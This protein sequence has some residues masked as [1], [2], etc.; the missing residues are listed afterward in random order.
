MNIF[1]FLISDWILMIPISDIMFGSLKQR[2][3]YE[4]N[5]SKMEL[6]AVTL[7]FNDYFKK[8]ISIGRS[9]LS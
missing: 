7:L 4:L 9:N 5:Y 2:Y 1:H 8:C 6:D 3:Y